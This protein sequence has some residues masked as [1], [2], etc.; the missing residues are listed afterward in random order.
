MPQRNPILIAMGDL[1]ADKYVLNVVE[2]VRANDL[3]E[4]LLVLPFSKVT[5]LIK[6]LDQWAKKVSHSTL[7]LCANVTLTQLRL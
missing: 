5:S 3:E 7:I 6:Y 2:K 1:P 4:A